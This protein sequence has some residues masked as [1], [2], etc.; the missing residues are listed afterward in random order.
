MKITH[1]CWEWTSW[2]IC[3]CWYAFSSIGWKTWNRTLKS[4]QEKVIFW[5]FKPF[6]LFLVRSMSWSNCFTISAFKKEKLLLL[7]IIYFF[8]SFY[9]LIIHIIKVRMVLI[10]WIIPV[11]SDFQ[12]LHWENKD[13]FLMCAIKMNAEAICHWNTCAKE[14]IIAVW[15]FVFFKGGLW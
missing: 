4:S 5:I 14:G 2:M 10:H 3:S 6:L 13:Y 9:Y 15:N 11:A 8:A 1:N 12:I 7:F